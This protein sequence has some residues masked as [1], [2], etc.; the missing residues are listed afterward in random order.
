MLVAIGTAAMSFSFLQSLIIPVLPAIGRDLH[1]SQEAVT[2]VL[3]GYLMSASVTTPLLGRLGDM[4]GKRRMLLVTMATLTAGV[5]LAGLAPG[6]VLLVA[7]RIV[8]GVWGALFPLAFGIIRDE[9]PAERVAGAI[10]LLSATLGVG[11]ALGVTLAG[12]LTARLG[13]PPFPRH[14]TGA[15]CLARSWA[16]CSPRSRSSQP[17]GGRRGT[18]QTRWSMS[19]C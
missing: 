3:T 9:L 14:Q 13:S 16:P 8:Q 5:A 19:G 17:G 12:P 1:V 6:L 7:A 18:R 4:F 15:G 11:G 10:G 2:W